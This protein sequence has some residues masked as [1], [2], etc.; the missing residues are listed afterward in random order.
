MTT[1]VGAVIDASVAPISLH[2]LLEVCHSGFWESW[3]TA[4]LGVDDYFRVKYN[5]N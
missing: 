4:P 5:L 2:T 3:V 1:H